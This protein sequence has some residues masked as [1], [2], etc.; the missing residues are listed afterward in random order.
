[1]SAYVSRRFCI[2]K[3]SIVMLLSASLP[4][5]SHRS[6]VMTLCIGN[7]R[8]YSSTLP[9]YCI[10][11]HLAH[12]Q[13]LLDQKLSSFFSSALRRLPWLPALQY[14]HLKKS[15]SAQLTA[16]MPTAVTTALFSGANAAFM[17]VCTDDCAFCWLVRPAGRD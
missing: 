6:T 3:S 14:R 2:P 10:S 17:T 1:M 4:A 9:L 11:S 12:T 13:P 7:I 16:N 8:E 15:H 5:S